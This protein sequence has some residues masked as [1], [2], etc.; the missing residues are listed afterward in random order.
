MNNNKQIKDLLGK[1]L[2]AL[3]V[4]A[5]LHSWHMTNKQM[6]NLLNNEELKEATDKYIEAAKEL[7]KKSVNSIHVILC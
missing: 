2:T 7:K 5:G 1:I 4:S 3:T 6:Q